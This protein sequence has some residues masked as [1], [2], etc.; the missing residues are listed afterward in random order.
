M[1]YQNIEIGDKANTNYK[2]YICDTE[3][4]LQR[5]PNEFASI[6]LVLGE[7]STKAS[8]WV[9]GTNGWKKIS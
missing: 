7:G 2:E 5:I 4:D 8:V 6:A 3:E 1:A 9:C